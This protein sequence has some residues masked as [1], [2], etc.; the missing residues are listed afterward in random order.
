MCIPHVCIG[1]SR[2]FPATLLISAHI[3]VQVQSNPPMRRVALLHACQ[4][5][6][7]SIQ[8]RRALCVRE[9]SLP[10]NSTAFFSFVHR[11]KLA[12]VGWVFALL[13]VHAVIHVEILPAAEWRWMTSHV[14]RRIFV[15]FNRLLDTM[16]MSCFCCCT[17]LSTLRRLWGTPAS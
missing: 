11:V 8:S 2:P 1:W 9:A 3:C 12:L 6:S 14:H 17:P 13:S 7:Q 16:H 10:Q 5:P 15:Q 4:L